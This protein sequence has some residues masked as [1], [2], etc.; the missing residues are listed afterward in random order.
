MAYDCQ[1]AQCRSSG[2][3]KTLYIQGVHLGA[4][5]TQKRLDIRRQ[6]DTSTQSTVRSNTDMRAIVRDEE[7]KEAP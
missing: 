6:L 2:I 1:G 3:V 5:H 7:Y 4:V